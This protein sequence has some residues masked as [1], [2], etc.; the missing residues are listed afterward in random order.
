MIDP[1]DQVTL[2]LPVTT[3]SPIRLRF[4]SPERLYDAVL[5]QD[6]F[7]DWLVIQCWS[8][9][10]T[11]NGGMKTTVVEDFEA[12]KDILDAITK[13]RLNRGYLLLTT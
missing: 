6:L 11:R 3:H 9:R 12:G 8:G 5:M 2:P 4:A 10:Q 1:I 7:E 13:R